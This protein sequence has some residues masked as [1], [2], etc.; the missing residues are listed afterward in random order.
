[1]KLFQGLVSP[2]Y[3]HILNKY[4]EGEE[5]Q[6]FL[7]AK[8]G[9]LVGAGLQLPTVSAHFEDMFRKKR[10]FD[11]SNIIDYSQFDE[12]TIRIY[13]DCVH[14]IGI[15]EEKLGFEQLLKLIQFIIAEGKT[16]INADKVS[17]FDVDFLKATL[18][19]LFDMEMEPETRFFCCL[20]LSTASFKYSKQIETFLPVFVSKMSYD[21]MK[22]AAFNAHIRHN[23]TEDRVK[24]I[25]DTEPTPDFLKQFLLP[26]SE[27]ISEVFKFINIYYAEVISGLTIN[28]K[29]YGSTSEN[30]DTVNI[31]LDLNEKISRVTYLHERGTNNWDDSYIWQLCFETT[32]G[33]T[34]GPY[35]SCDPD[36]MELELDKIEVRVSSVDDLVIVEKDGQ[37]IERIEKKK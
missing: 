8:N 35:G 36:D 20:V 17:I 10:N 16:A 25:I 37:W 12:E 22:S 24:K 13:I 5:N 27:K 30:W 4:Q 9:N 11:G 6:Y 23:E 15:P 31:K 32:L 26:T 29:D 7:K 19:T 21:Q 3:P 1:M 33:K 14:N 28:G 2:C 18:N 34:Y